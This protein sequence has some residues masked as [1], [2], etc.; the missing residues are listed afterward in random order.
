MKP[1]FLHKVKIV[2]RKIDL[3]A[4][5]NVA[6]TFDRIRREQAAAKKATETI[7]RPIRKAVAK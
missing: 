6:V 4:P 3:Y 7:V 5:T 2:G 1:K